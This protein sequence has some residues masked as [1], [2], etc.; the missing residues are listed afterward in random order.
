MKQSIWHRLTVWGI[1]L[2]PAVVYLTLIFKFPMGYIWATYE[3]LFGEWMQFWFFVI[4]FTYCVRLAWKGSR[5][6][7]FFG[8]LGLCCFYVA[9]EEISWGQRLLNISS[10]DFFREHNIQKEMNIHNFFTGPI[11]TPL[12]AGLEYALFMAFMGYGVVYPLMLKMRVKLFMWMESKGL[13]SPP[14]SPVALFSNR[15]RLRVESLSF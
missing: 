2:L 11:G 9:M 12:K 10:P 7:L 3:D 8:V 4:T 5:Y 14:P 13:P 1:F 6:R 15:R